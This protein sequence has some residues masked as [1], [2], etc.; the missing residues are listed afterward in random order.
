MRSDL[1]I[2]FQILSRLLFFRRHRYPGVKDWELEKYLGR[3][4]MD[5][6]EE[7][8]KYIE[9]LGLEVVW[10]DIEMGDRRWRHFYVRPRFESIPIDIKAHGWSIEDMATLSVALS[11]IIAGGGKALRRDIEEILS[12]KISKYKVV[13]SLGRLIRANYLVEEGEHI[14]IGLRSILE[15]DMDKLSTLII[16]TSGKGDETSRGDSSSH[17]L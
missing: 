1:K 11:M 15:I 5:V 4:Y 12:R 8:N 17:T 10:K 2:K 9:P 6:I 7:F 3:R 16:S 14:K 13:R